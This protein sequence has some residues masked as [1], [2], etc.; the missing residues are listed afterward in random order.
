MREKIFLTI[1]VLLF[2]TKLFAHKEWVHQY[3]LWESY[4]YM[5]QEKGLNYPDMFNYMGYGVHGGG[6]DLQPWALGTINQGV[7]Q[8]DYD[9]AV[10][11]Y[12]AGAFNGW[13]PS[14]THFWDA[15]FGDD[16][17]TP[18]PASP[19]APNAWQKAKAYLFGGHTIYRKGESQFYYNGYFIH[20]LGLFYSYNSL[21]DLYITGHCAFEGYVD[22]GDGSTHWIHDDIYLDEPNRKAMAYEIL[23]RV[24]HLLGD[25][26]VPAHVHNDIHPCNPP[27]PVPP[28][29]DPYEIY[30]GGSPFGNDCDVPQLMFPAQIYNKTTAHNYDLNH[31]SFIDISS[32]NDYDA[33]RYLFYTQNQIADHFQTGFYAGDNAL[34]NGSNQFLLDRYSILGPP[35]YGNSYSLTQIANECFNYSI[36]TTSALLYWFARKTNQ[37]SIPV[38]P[39]ITQITCSTP[40]GMVY[41]D[42]TATFVCQP[43]NGNLNTCYN[44]TVNVCNKYNC[45]NIIIPGLSFTTF[46]STGPILSIINTNYQGLACSFCHPTTPDAEQNMYLKISVVANC[47]GQSTSGSYCAPF[48]N[49][50]FIPAAGHRPYSGCPYVYVQNDSGRFISDNNIL[51]RSEFIENVGQ[52]ISDKYLLNIHPGVFDSKLNINLFESTHDISSINSIK[53]LAIDHPVGTKIGVS[54][55]N[56]IVMYY[57]ADA[58]DP[59]KANK[60]HIEDIT[61]L[62]QVTPTSRHDTVSGIPEDEIASG[63]DTDL[64]GQRIR[65]SRNKFNL[66]KNKNSSGDNTALIFRAGRNPIDI[67]PP[68]KRPGGIISIS[69]DSKSIELPF[70]RREIASDIIIPIGQDAIVQSANIKWD[71]DYQ[72]YYAAVVDIFYNGFDITELPLNSAFST[73][74]DEDILLNL[75]EIDGNYASLDSTGIISLSFSDVKGNSGMIRDYVIETNG[76]YSANGTENRHV[77]ISGKNLKDPKQDLNIF[78]NKLNVNFPNPFNPTTKINYQISKNGLVSLKVYNVLGQLISQL[79]NEFKTAGVYT[80]EFN[81]S[82]LATGV[83]YYRIET[84]DFIETKRMMLIK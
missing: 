56:D 52:E 14:S 33:I 35:V 17:M 64:Q 39:A 72:L 8:E 79:V 37:N 10:F 49:C 82:N 70:S 61:N 42:E 34:P 71:L 24:V 74:L 80:V 48:P 73:S 84:S 29:P 19:N 41:N 54:E 83:Y 3:L 63:F 11:R 9:D 59:K 53:L 78:T 25:M 6:N 27:F 47:F 16:Y 68:V 18:I 5:V 62:I 30:M 31:P 77:N 66:L 4:N 51:H 45:D 26:S 13:V 22:F 60:N 55:S 23:G 76:Q 67:T 69:T 50:G 36:K 65:L 43:N 7:W 75:Q 81:G 38:L 12:G 58:T 21:T 44:W 32:M 40:D 28:D 46:G 1:F 57:E 2:A 15:D 20:V